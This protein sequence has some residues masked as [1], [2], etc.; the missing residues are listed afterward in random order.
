M[1]LKLAFVNTG[2]RTQFNVGN[3]DQVNLIDAVGK[4]KYFVVRDSQDACVCSRDISSLDA[5][6]R[7]NVW[8]KFPA[9]PDDVQKITVVVP[10]FQPLEGIAIIQ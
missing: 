8:A 4:K 9:P 5:N 3:L 2:G 10:Q 1:T 7:A 6:A